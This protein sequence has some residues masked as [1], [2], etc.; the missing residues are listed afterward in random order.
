[1]FGAKSLA[2]FSRYDGCT[3]ADIMRHAPDPGEKKPRDR[4]REHDATDFD[5]DP[6]LAPNDNLED[7]FRDFEVFGDAGLTME[8][9]EPS[10]R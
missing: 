10:R 5:F 8:D 9:V 6:E 1:M 4:D 7:A 3:E 2:S